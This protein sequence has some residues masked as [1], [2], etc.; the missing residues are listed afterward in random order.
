MRYLYPVVLIPEQEGGY[1]V[2]VPDL[3]GCVTQGDTAE[4]A[5]AMAKDAMEGWPDPSRP[6]MID[7]PNRPVLTYVQLPNNQRRLNAQG[8]SFP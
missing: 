4:E 8:R 2:I 1:S 5:F 6:P 3:P 7:S